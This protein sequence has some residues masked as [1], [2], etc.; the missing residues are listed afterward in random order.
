MFL[1]NDFVT[2]KFLQD[3]SFLSVKFEKLIV[4]PSSCQTQSGELSVSSQ[5]SQYDSFSRSVTVKGA[6]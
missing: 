3:E 5:F 6:S 2:T 4:S 1:K